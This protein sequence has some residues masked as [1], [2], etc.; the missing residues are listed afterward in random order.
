MPNTKSLSDQA[1]GVTELGHAVLDAAAKRLL[2]WKD[3]EC[4]GIVCS[5]FVT[6]IRRHTALVT[7]CETHHAQEAMMLL[8]GHRRIAR[9]FCAAGATAGWIC[10]PRRAT[11]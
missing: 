11:C 4:E 9:R 2:T 8:R 5:L 6:T 3:T 1:N 7:L 10:I